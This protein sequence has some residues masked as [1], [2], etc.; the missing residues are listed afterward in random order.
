MQNPSQIKDMVPFITGL[1]TDS[2]RSDLSWDAGDL[3]NWIAFED[4][5]LDLKG[6][7]RGGG[8]FGPKVGLFGVKNGLLTL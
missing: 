1:L 8:V 4:Q 7:F 2:E 3:F 6:V 5:R